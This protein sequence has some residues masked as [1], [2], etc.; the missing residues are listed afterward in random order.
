MKRAIWILWPSFVVAGIAEIV[1]FSLFD[2]I[3]LH[4]VGSLFGIGRRGGYTVGFLLFWMFAAASSAFTCFLQRTAAEVNRCPLAP[5][6][7]PPGCL[8][9]GDPSAL[10][11]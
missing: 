3:E 11:S 5:G 7:R 8:K 1:F 2:P 9:R 4:I 10:C 6:V